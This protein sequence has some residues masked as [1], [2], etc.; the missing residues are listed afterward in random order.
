MAG[1]SATAGPDNDV[2][3]VIHHV[4]PGRTRAPFLRYFR[5][6]LPRLTKAILLIVIAAIGALAA[7]VARGGYPPFPHGEL[8]LWL[9]TV[10]AVIFLAFGVTRLRIWDFGLVP[11]GGAIL[12]YF[13]GLFSDT[14]P[15]VWHGAS[16]PL[17]AAYTLLLALSVG[18]LVLY[19]A[20]NYGM[21][22]AYP[23]NQNFHD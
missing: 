16:E 14:A 9:V 11:A 4:K 15:Y 6:N 2:E 20:L 1:T 7:I 13:A 23:D 5:F 22:V 3:M 12:I 19:W 18:Y 10:T 21:I 8:A 17:A